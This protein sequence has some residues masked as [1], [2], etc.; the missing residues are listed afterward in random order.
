MIDRMALFSS[1]NLADNFSRSVRKP[2]VTT[3][4]AIN[5]ILVVD[6]QKMQDSCLDIVDIYC[7]FGNVESVLVCHAVHMTRFDT[8]SCQ[9]ECETTSVV[10][11][12]VLFH[13]GVALC[14]GGAAKLSVF[15]HLMLR[16]GGKSG[17]MPDLVTSGL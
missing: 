3:L 2:E 13:L 9:P 17:N 15:M 8:C 7:V 4:E 11:A 1:Q 10:I 5:Q 16:P 12:A 6:T 14:I